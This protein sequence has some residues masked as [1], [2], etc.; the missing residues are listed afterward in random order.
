MGRTTEASNPAFYVR[1]CTEMPGNPDAENM[2][3][4]EFDLC[5][6]PISVLEFRASFE[7]RVLEDTEDRPTIEAELGLTFQMMGSHYSEMTG[8]SSSCPTLG[9]PFPTPLGPPEPVWNFRLTANRSTNRKRSMKGN[10]IMKWQSK[11]SMALLAALGLWASASAG[12]FRFPVGVSGASGFYN[13]LDKMDENWHFEDKFVFP[14]GLSFNPYYEFD[15]GLGIGASMGPTGFYFVEEHRYGYSYYSEDVKFSYVIPVGLDLRYTFFR[16]SNFS[17]YVRGG[18]RYPIAG[19]D[20]ISGS[21]PG[22]FG[23][24]GIE[25]LRTKKI[26]FGL[27]FG[28]DGSKVEVERGPFGGEKDARFAEF[29]GSIFVVF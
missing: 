29:M 6:L 19:G 21:D 4:P 5:V 16:K 8:T 15:F 3:S 7:H 20:M 26:G 2:P 27:E 9:K 17:P 22:P 12:E 18:F 13:I 23:A 24:I 25:F 11:C 14:V 1:F 28:Y 10:S